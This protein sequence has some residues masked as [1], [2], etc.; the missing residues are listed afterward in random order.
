MSETLTKNLMPGT[1]SDAT[2]HSPGSQGEHL[3][4]KVY[5]T[6]ERAGRFYRDQMCNRLL[7]T[8]IEFIG[9]MEMMFVGAAD[10]R[11]ECECNPAGRA[12]RIRADACRKHI[13]RMVPIPSRGSKAADNV[14]A[15]ESQICC[16]VGVRFP[17]REVDRWREMTGPAQLV[18]GRRGDPPARQAGY[19]C[20]RA[21]QSRVRRPF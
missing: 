17:H 1:E 6:A 13:P 9:R 5:G 2:S 12:S 7:P 10:R 8:M 11:G 16:G 4:Q 3:L 15:R 21:R 14:I 18:M 19:A 20:A